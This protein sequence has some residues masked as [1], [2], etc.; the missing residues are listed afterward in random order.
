MLTSGDPGASNV[1]NLIA[2]L[3][4]GQ[5]GPGYG[6]LPPDMRTG[7]VNPG[8]SMQPYVGGT[9]PNGQAALA[10]LMAAMS[11]TAGA[12]PLQ[13]GQDEV[14]R[15]N[16]NGA[17]NQNAGRFMWGNR[18]W[19]PNDFSQF[20]N[21]LKSNGVDM[22]QWARA[23]PAAFASFNI[24]PRIKQ[25]IGATAPQAAGGMGHA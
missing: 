5:S 21:Y 20:A 19:G 11:R 4:S 18:T 25:L 15:G 2:Q 14:M 10:A 3:L 8:G 12:M 16:P 24:D 22:A 6:G 17:G 7:Q 23:H 1:S 13:R 9:S